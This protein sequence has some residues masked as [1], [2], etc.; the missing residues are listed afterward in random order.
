[1]PDKTSTAVMAKDAAD[2][3]S[4]PAD[5]PWHSCATSWS[6]NGADPTL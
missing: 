5:D 2:L 4:L 1:M 6:P 3:A